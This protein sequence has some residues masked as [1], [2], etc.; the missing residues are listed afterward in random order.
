MGSVPEPSE[1]QRGD[2]EVD[3]YPGDIVRHRYE[4]PCGYGRVRPEPLEEERN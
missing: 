4:G 2:Q 1:H 3:D